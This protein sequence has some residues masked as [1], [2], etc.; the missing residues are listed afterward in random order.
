MSALRRATE[1]ACWALRAY[2]WP[3]VWL[4]LAGA[5][6]L[7]VALPVL[8]G[9]THLGLSTV[10]PA[11]FGIEWTS[12]AVPPAETQRR[13]IASL[14]EL[15]VDLAVTVLG[16]AVLTITVL[17]FARASARRTELA[18]RRAVGAR[19]REL[20][21]AAFVEGIVLVAIALG[22]GTSA[23][24]VG[25]RLAL[26]AWPGTASPGPLGPV[27]VAVAG[28]AGVILGGA[29]LSALSRSARGRRVTPSSAPQ[30]LVLPALQ[31]GISLALLVAAGQLG[32]V[33]GAVAGAAPGLQTDALVYDVMAPEPPALRAARYA[34]LL[35]RLAAEPAFD[36]VSLTS[37]G[38][39]AG[40]GTEDVIL[41]D[42]G[43]CYDGGLPKPIH[44][45][46]AALRAV[47][48][49]TFRALRVP[50]VAG[51]GFEALDD[52]G[53]APVVVVNERLAAWH[54]EN[55]HAV[56]RK[57]FLGRHGWYT[58]IG[59]VRDREGPGF[60]AG[61]LS[62]YAV[63]V[64]ALQQ[65]PDHAQLLVVP[66]PG[67]SPPDAGALARATLGGA[68]SVTFRGS[69]SRLL[70]V[71]AAPVR[72]FGRFFAL[73]GN[74][75]FLI[76]LLGTFAVLRMWVQGALLELAVRRAVGARRRRVLGFVLARA[77]GVGVSGV[78]FGLWLGIMVSG[79]LAEVL[80]GLPTRTLGVVFG[81]A[82]GLVSAAIAG[83]LVPAWRAVR[84][85]PATLLSSAEA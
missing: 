54:F 14:S 10:R 67:V 31:L 22:L 25:G 83:A 66:R 43:R 60:G 33:A 81:P 55:G 41:T 64:S 74:V 7:A 5:L 62:R 82:L 56:G 49:D 9:A 75:A 11:D 76:A 4:S 8:A 19:R 20:L 1:S 12:L 6:A 77:L 72:W 48:P 28:I 85:A 63:Y 29:L 13:A 37:A 47:S 24:L 30:G 36:A 44:D 26:A 71:E 16:V 42:C 80:P 3:A 52:R 45:V 78:L 73:E 65:P 70:A 27:T 15:L 39:S 23:G 79:L 35:R 68:A 17:S 34:S 57:V 51:R 38:T 40:L 18:V 46:V 50:L 61:L 59:V 84:A 21:G 69:G 53:A 58:V 32:R 2:A